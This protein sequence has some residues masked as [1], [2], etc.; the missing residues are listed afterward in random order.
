MPWGDG[1]GRDGCPQE[2]LS[3]LWRGRPGVDRSEGIL[4]PSDQGS[5]LMASFE[6]NSSLKALCPNTA[7]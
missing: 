3:K 5:V 1:E 7:T 2:G 6:L 4:V